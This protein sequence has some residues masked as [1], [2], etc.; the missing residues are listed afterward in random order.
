LGCVY[1]EIVACVPIKMGCVPVV[2]FSVEEIDQDPLLATIFVLGTKVPRSAGCT[3][4]AQAQQRE[5]LFSG[6]K[7]SERAKFCCQQPRSTYKADRRSSG[8]RGCQVARDLAQKVAPIVQ[9]RSGSSDP[10]GTGGSQSALRGSVFRE[11]RDLPFIAAEIVD[12]R[13]AEGTFGAEPTV[14][15]PGHVKRAWE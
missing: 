3:G 13:N 10:V 9:D 8:F 12:R 7:S 2:H 1:V 15:A 6:Y 14:L 5:N 4:S 11:T